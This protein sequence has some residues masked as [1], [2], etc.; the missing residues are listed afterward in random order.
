MRIGSFL[1]TPPTT[2][3]YQDSAVYESA[4]LPIQILSF[5][6]IFISYEYGVHLPPASCCLQ[7]GV[8]YSNAHRDIVVVRE[9]G[10]NSFYSH[11]SAL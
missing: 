4:I 8:L 9:G 3:L 5:F 11:F 10:R 6:D 1:Y 7:V 2:W